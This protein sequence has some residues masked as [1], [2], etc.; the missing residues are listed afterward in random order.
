MASARGGFVRIPSSLLDHLLTIRFSASELRIVLWVVRRTLGWNRH[1]TLFTWYQIAK[2][3][4]L[5]RA[6][7]LRAGKAL[8]SRDV[9][10]VTEGRIGMKGADVPT[11]IQGS[12]NGDASHR[13]TPNG[14]DASHRM[15]CLESPVYRRAIDSSKDKERYIRSADPMA[16]ATR[17]RTTGYI[18]PAG[19]ARPVEGKYDDI[20]TI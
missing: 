10:H 20:S 16:E 17:V 15:R 3:L 14:G 18:H 1:T 13:V 11:A 9:L 2:D 4:Q 6:G 12:L 7:V 5:D 19:S 8:V